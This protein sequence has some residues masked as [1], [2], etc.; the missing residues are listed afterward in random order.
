M[1]KLAT[2]SSPETDR[3]IFDGVFTLAQFSAFMLPGGAVFAGIIAVFQMVFDHTLWGQNS[4]PLSTVVSN[5]IADEVKQDTLETGFARMIVLYDWFKETYETDWQ[6]DDTIDPKELAVFETQLNDALGPNSEF[7]VFLQAM[8]SKRYKEIGFSAFMFG[9]ALRLALMKVDAILKS[10]DRGITKIPE[11]K[12]LQDVMKG[13][14]DYATSTKADIDAKIEDRLNKVSPL[15]GTS[16]TDEGT[17]TD[18]QN[19]IHLKFGPY[20]NAVQADINREAYLEELRA[21]LNLAKFQS[22]RPDK[23]DATILKW[24]EGQ[25]NVE[26]FLPG[27]N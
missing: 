4:L 3:E 1:E 24:K 15:D 26:P 18:P 10:F 19:P 16:F 25:A 5:A 14:A 12:H 2:S 6:D 17:S 22:Q 21:K 8:Q 20:S 9:A 13:Y 7:L 23:I 11:W 27:K